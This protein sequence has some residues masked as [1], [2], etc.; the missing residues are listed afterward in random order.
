MW[1]QFYIVRDHCC[2]Y[3]VIAQL[4]HNSW[5][6]LILHFKIFWQLQVDFNK[7][8]ALSI[9]QTLEKSTVKVYFVITVL[10]TVWH[11]F[12]FS[13]FWL[14]IFFI[15]MSNVIPFPVF[16]CESPPS[17]T[18]YQLTNPPTPASWPW[19]SPTLGH[20]AF[21]GPRVS[22]PIDDL[23]GHPLLHMQ[24]EP[25]VPPCVIFGWWFSP[26]ELWGYWLVLV[27]VPPMGLQTPWVLSLAPP[28]GIL[29]SVQ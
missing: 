27:V 2:V 14:D 3:I 11:L 25:R 21:T 26:W 28:L 16:P 15:Y 12:F 23:Q 24:L 29:C 19:H 1:I 17:P 5:R 13:F 20:R 9:E 10:S 4:F 6:K 8:E 22:P 18:P 7:H